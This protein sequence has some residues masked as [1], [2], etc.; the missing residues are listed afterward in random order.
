MG[1][2][3][4]YRVIFSLRDTLTTYNEDGERDSL[5]YCTGLLYRFNPTEKQGKNWEIVIADAYKKTTEKK[6]EESFISFK[7]ETIIKFPGTKSLLNESVYET[8]KRGLKDNAGYTFKDKMT[9]VHYFQY[10]NLD[11]ESDFPHH[12]KLFFMKEVV[13]DAKD[14]FLKRAHI[15]QLNK[16]EYFN[17]RWV[18]LSPILLDQVSPS[19]RFA[20]EKLLKRLEFIPK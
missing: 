2:S 1:K 8:L 12:L 14:D 4:D 5:F 6:S 20:L 7:K 19:H 13:Y 11:Y 16:K 10:Y 15:S 3:I 9:L 17:Q 18:T